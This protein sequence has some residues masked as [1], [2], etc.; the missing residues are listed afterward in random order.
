MIMID[1]PL[2][3]CCRKCFCVDP[4]AGLRLD[5]MKCK[6]MEAAGRR[7]C[8]VLDREDRPQDCPIRMGTV[9]VRNMTK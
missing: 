9:S 4:R 3:E 2:P 8:L 1:V 6:A 7:Y 5:R